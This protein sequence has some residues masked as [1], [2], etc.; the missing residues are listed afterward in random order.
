M[1]S[2]EYDVFISYS[3]QDAAFVDT[4]VG[5]LKKHGYSCYRDVNE[6]KPGS[7][8][9]TELYA[10]IDASAKFLYVLSP[11]W[12]ASNWCKA[13]IKYAKKADKP[14]IAVLYREVNEADLDPSVARIEWIDYPATDDQD[15]DSQKLVDAIEFDIDYARAHA[16]LLAR[17]R[18]WEQGYRKADLTVRGRDLRTAEEFLKT[19]G[20]KKP[21]PTA[22]Q[23]EYVRASQRRRFWRVVML[24]LLGIALVVSSGAFAVVRNIANSKSLEAH[25]KAIEA[26][27]LQ[28]SNDAQ[29]ALSDGNTDL[30]IAL[31]LQA[32]KIDNPPVQ[33]QRVLESAAFSPG[34]RLRLTGHSNW[35]WSFATSPNGQYIA[36]ASFDNSIILWELATGMQVRRLARPTSLAVRAVVFTP[37]GK[38]LLSGSDDG[39]VVVWD[40]PTGAIVRTYHPHSGEIRSLALTSDGATAL[41]GYNDGHLLSLNVSNGLVKHLAQPIQGN[42]WSV[43]LSHNGHVAIVGG[44]D[45]SLLLWNLD[46]FRS[47]GQLG[48]PSA[49][50]LGVAFSPDGKTALSGGDDGIVRVWDVTRKILIG[51]LEGHDASAWVWGVAFSSDGRLAVSGANDR[52]VLLWDV[53]TGQ[54]IHQF[55]GHDDEVTHVGFAPNDDNVIISASHDKTLRIWDAQS[56]GQTFSSRQHTGAIRSIAVSPDGKLALSTGADGKLILWDLVRQA[57]IG[58]IGDYKTPMLAAVMGRDNRTAL[59]AGGTLDHSVI[60]WDLVNRVE[61]RRLMGHT[62][63][64]TSLAISPDG[65]MAASGSQDGQIILWDLAT[66]KEVRRLVGHDRW[67]MS[68]AFAPDG[69]TLLSGGFDTTV[70]LWDVATG[71]ELRTFIGHHDWVSTVAFS[72]DGRKVLSGSYDKTL[73]AWDAASGARLWEGS[74]HAGPITSIAISSGGNV[75]ASASTDRQIILWDVV[76]GKQFRQIQENTSV[77]SLAFSPDGRTILSGSKDGTLAAWQQLLNSH[78]VLQWLATHRYVRDLTS[79]EKRQFHVTQA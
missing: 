50:A 12:A 39:N 18:H 29:Q 74:A 27:S 72:P 47:E 55:I 51:K 32:N 68:L 7:D 41:I 48:Q 42:I 22:L 46:T 36:S 53:E 31:A 44:Q 6:R 71:K 43:A 76:T 4:I 19:S 11:A 26:Q 1:A 77:Y 13:E 45:G 3:R 5:V 67:V 66:G 75:V 64:V 15:A 10:A 69:R 56:G 65:A 52:K 24:S 34:T 25:N 16:Y 49:Q 54:L 59:V 35:V 70:R 60:V 8:I 58:E 2:L 14:L 63:W 62:N 79:A 61:V 30:A 37:D 38:E 21:P 28:L 23:R 20:G 9:P 57:P 73:I 78:D 33:A 17:A 40:V